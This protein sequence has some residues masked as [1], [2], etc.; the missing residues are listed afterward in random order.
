MSWW[1]GIA[2]WAS[3]NSGAL[4]AGGSTLLGGA[5]ANI[6][7]RNYQEDQRHFVK[8]MSNTAYSRAVEDMRRAGLNPLLL[9]GGTPAS[10]PA[11]G[12]PQGQDMIGPAV[13][14][15]MAYKRLEQE[16]KVMKETEKNIRID[17]GKKSAEHNYWQNK[18]V[19]EGITGELLSTELP[20]AKAMEKIW[21]EGGAEL[22]GLQKILE[23][24]G[25]IRNLGGGNSKL[26]GDR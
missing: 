2:N 19:V 23:L 8:E 7:S 25:K 13:A 11:S 22:G 3:N 21:K 9:G 10:T 24:L 16:L 12:A 20:S 17:T 5:I 4:I 6:Y 26:R 1:S 14:S 15:A 18:S